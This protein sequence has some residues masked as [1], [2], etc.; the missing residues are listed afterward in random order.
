MDVRDGCQKEV[1]VVVAGG[2]GRGGV[3]GDW[4]GE[5]GVA[6]CVCVCERLGGLS[7]EMVGFGE[8]QRAA[9]QWLKPSAKEHTDSLR[10][11]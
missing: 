4:G 1:D 9:A 7:D 8:L 10:E 2:G 11:L 6:T 3:A 5:I